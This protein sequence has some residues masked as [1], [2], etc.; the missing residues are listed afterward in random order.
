M[1]WSSKIV[2]F[3]NIVAVL[4]LFCSYL[5]PGIDPQHYWIFS[6]FA[7]MYPILVIA[8]VVFILFWSFV[9]IKYAL[10]SLL[11][12]L[13]GYKNFSSYVGFNSGKVTS[14]SHNISVVSYNISN[15]I[16]AYDKRKDVKENKKEKMEGF[17]SRFKDE[18]ILC[19]QEVGEYATDIIK[20]NFKDYHIH[21]FDKGTIILS[22]HKMIKKGQIEFGTKTNSCLWADIVIGVD[23][24]RVYSIHLQSN[25][26][27]KDANEMIAH[28]SIKEEKTWKNLYGIFRKYNIYHKTRSVQAKTVKEHA[29]LS[30]YKVIMC[31]DFNDVPLSYNYNVLQHNLVD[32]FKEKGVG[33]GSTFNG[34]IP[35][36]RIDYILIDPD[37]QVAKFNV[38]RENYSDHYAVAAVIALKRV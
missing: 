15:A 19:L 8:N 33:I 14:S 31:G 16:E 10:L 21:K 11:A 13:F 2:F 34:K 27:S 5:A 6:F 36:L 35:F 23:T 30:P 12:L 26:I 7:L 37:Y 9:E 17:L 4:C 32:A 20:K 1:K 22:K 24:V 3:L 29:D 38:V 25:K 18:D 28:G